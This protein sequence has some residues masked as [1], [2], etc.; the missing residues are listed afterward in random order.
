M[1]GEVRP[2]RDALDFPCERIGHCGRLM[3]G[4]ATPV[5]WLVAV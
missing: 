4:C 3:D 5:R 1:A 2:V